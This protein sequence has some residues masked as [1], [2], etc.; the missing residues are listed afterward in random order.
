MDTT[1]EEYMTVYAT[2]SGFKRPHPQRRHRYKGA[3]LIIN[4]EM[5]RVNSLPAATRPSTT[6][7]SIA[8]PPSLRPPR[9]YCDIT[10]L[11]AHYTAPLNQIRY[12]DS[13]CYQLVKNMPP[14]VDQQYLSLR[15]ANVILK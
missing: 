1:L 8:A 14:G 3:R 12:F 5:R 4:D 15:G 6:Y 10:G 13:E 11:P 7:M 2:A 9:K